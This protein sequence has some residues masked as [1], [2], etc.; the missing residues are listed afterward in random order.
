MGAQARACADD[1]DAAYQQVRKLYVDDPICID[2]VQPLSNTSTKCTVRAFVEGVSGKSYELEIRAAPD[3]SQYVLM[4]E[5][6]FD[7]A[8]IVDIQLQALGYGPSATPSGG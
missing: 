1:R 4:D 8:A 5:W 2:G 6:W 7:E 3:G